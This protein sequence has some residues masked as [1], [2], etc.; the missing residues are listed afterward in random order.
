MAKSLTD[1]VKGVKFS[2]VKSATLG[3]DPGVD[4]Q[5]KAPAEQEFVASRTVEKHADRVGNGDDIYQA[6]NVKPALSDTK[7]EPRYGRRNNK[8]AEKAEYPNSPNAS[9]KEETKCNH[10]PKGTM[11][12]VH[13]MAECSSGYM[14]K[15]KSK[16]KLDEVLKKNTPMKTYI[17]DFE[18]SDAPQFAGKSQEKRRQMA[19][20]AKYAAQ[21][22][23]VEIEEVAKTN[24]AHIKRMKKKDI[25]VNEP[26]SNFDMDTHKV[27]LTV[28][29]DGNSEKIKHTLKA[30]DK[31]AAVAASQREFYKKGYKVHDAVHKGI[32]GEAVQPLLG[33][34]DSDE[35]VD[36]VKTELRAL[37]NKAMHLVMA[38]PAGMHVEPWVQS[39]LA[40]AKE[41]VSSVHDYM[42][43]GDH[44]EDEQ[45]DT[46]ITF[47]NM[48]NDSAAGINV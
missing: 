9:M 7:K 46:P 11:C 44:K 24:A 18:K 37:A 15:E 17:D 40:Q 29:K 47:P 35:A 43:Y 13:G 1:I 32:L 19:I 34:H 22:E 31:H 6:T 3:K 45:T 38:M 21:K 36:M 33:S 23:E 27:T 25:R 12:E 30:K 48:A 20:A 16:K 2:T 14:I 10:S 5:P 28:S 4:Y 8:E 41:M 26:H 39:K 42:I